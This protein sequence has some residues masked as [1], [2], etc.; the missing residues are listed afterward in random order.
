MKNGGEPKETIRRLLLMGS[1]SALLHGII[2]ALLFLGIN[3]AK[4]N[5]IYRVEIKRLP[6]V[7]E[8]AEA[9]EPAAQ[10][11]PERNE[12]A[13]IRREP[14]EPV[15]I[16][17]TGISVPTLP[18]SADRPEETAARVD[19]AETPVPMA[20]NVIITPEGGLGSGADT[21]DGGGNSLL[22]SGTGSGWGGPAE[23]EGWGGGSGS[24]GAGG[25]TGGGYGSGDG[26]S[27][28][29][30]GG[31]TGEETGV[32]FV[33]MPGITPPGYIRTPQPNYP[34]A[35]RKRGEHGDVLLKVEVLANGRVGQTEVAASSGFAL[36]DEAAV[37]TV[38][39]WRFKPALKGR[40]EVAC[41]VNIPIRFKLR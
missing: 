39:S 2:A 1:V 28:G 10:E 18:E 31:A 6:P 16:D 36:L 15:V 19:I 13:E 24:P 34:E 12:Q 3:P 11:T 30:A 4:E 29:R 25:G 35:S 20:E 40:E 41:W 27:R 38:G 8:Q 32:Y 17:L 33:G 22:A 26:N 7:T 21:E 9:T 37:K 23:G 5:N 14:E